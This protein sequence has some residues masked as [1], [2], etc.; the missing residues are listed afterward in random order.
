MSN[1]L[2]LPKHFRI[3]SQSDISNMIWLMSKKVSLPKHFRIQ[4]QINIAKQSAARHL[5][6]SF[7]SKCKILKIGWGYSINILSVSFK[8]TNVASWIQNVTTPLLFHPGSTLKAPNP[9]A[10]A[11]GAS[12]ALDLLWIC[13]AGQAK[14]VTL[15]GHKCVRDIIIWYNYKASCATYLI[16]DPL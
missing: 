4:S 5:I 10:S 15:R 3:Q 14:L 7:Q 9:G 6:F 11:P 13:L 16:G 12:I 2:S 8:L 1:T